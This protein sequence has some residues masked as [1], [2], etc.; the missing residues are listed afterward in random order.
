M[1]YVIR[2]LI[3]FALGLGLASVSACA[4]QVPSPRPVEA[5]DSS[6][7][8]VVTGGLD[9]WDAPPMEVAEVVRHGDEGS[10]FRFVRPVF[11]A[12]VSSERFAVYDSGVREVIRVDVSDQSTVLLLRGQGP[13]EIEQLTS[14]AT[15]DDSLVLAN[16]VGNGKI[17]V[18]SGDSVLSSYSTAGDPDLGFRLSAEGR[19]DTGQFLMRTAV[20]P[21][22]SE[23]GWTTGHL[24]AADVDLAQLDTVLAFP[25]LLRPPQ[26][27]RNPFPPT[28]HAVVAGSEWVVGR[29]DQQSLVRVDADRG[30]VQIRR[31]TSEPEYPDRARFQAFRERF[32]AD[33]T[34]RRPGQ[35]APPIQMIHQELA[36]YE[37]RSDEALPHYGGLVGSNDGSVWM[38]EYGYPGEPSRY[39]VL[40]RDGVWSASV[41]FPVGF[42]LLAVGHGLAV[43]VE[44][45]PLGEQ[46]VVAYR[47]MPSGNQGL[48]MPP[49]N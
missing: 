17:L 28:G 22:P 31:W 10:D 18:L 43:G 2:P 6:G 26:E 25:I 11:A 15:I 34:S 7:V 27:R 20:L 33:A 5:R 36:R 4:D 16:D 14:L 23:P 35:V 39:A 48:D 42:R 37:M 3:I 12:V 32:L 46:V 9:P 21:T 40:G 30:V 44:M 38:S 13:G 45:E 8:T 1:K 24:V 29:S 47:L 41:A 19:L 49:G